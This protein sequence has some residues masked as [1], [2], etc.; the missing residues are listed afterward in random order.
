MNIL[1]NCATNST[2]FI[3]HFV[4]K[5]NDQAGRNDVCEFQTRPDFLAYHT[6]DVPKVI[7][8]NYSDYWENI[9]N[10]D[11]CMQGYPVWCSARIVQY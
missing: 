8:I 6:Y 10:P 11:L 5:V 3:L 9:F 4:I 7:Y 2:L 1:I